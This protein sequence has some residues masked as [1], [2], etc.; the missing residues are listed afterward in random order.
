MGYRRFNIRGDDGM[1]VATV[2]S[3]FI[4][5][6]GE[7]EG[8]LLIYL[9]VVHAMKISIRKQTNKCAS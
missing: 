7:S 1:W 9:I 3:H 6:F 4:L 8:K 5:F 2:V